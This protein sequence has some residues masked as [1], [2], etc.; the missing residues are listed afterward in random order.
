MTTACSTLFEQPC[1]ILSG[2]FKPYFH[3]VMDSISIVFSDNCHTYKNM[4]G[5]SAKG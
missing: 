4:L 2:L 3:F 5:S 1:Q